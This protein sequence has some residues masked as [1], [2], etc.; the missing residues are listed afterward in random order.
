MLYFSNIFF[1]E[2]THFLYLFYL[3]EVV[4]IFVIV[5]PLFDNL[6]SVISIVSILVVRQQLIRGGQH[7][8]VAID[9]SLPSIRIIF[10]RIR[11]VA[12]VVRVVDVD[13]WVRH[14]DVLAFV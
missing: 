7:M 14:V 1:F 13:V 11:S 6:D 5:V 3:L 10:V 2:V 12:S 8:L 9:R 4:F